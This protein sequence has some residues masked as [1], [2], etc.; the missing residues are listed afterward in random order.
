MRLTEL[1]AP[2]SSNWRST[3]ARRFA[4]SPILGVNAAIAS[5]STEEQN[6]ILAHLHAAEIH[7]IRSG[8]LPDENGVDFA[9]RARAQGIWIDWLVVRSSPDRMSV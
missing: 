5:V 4:E 8:I 3:S 7:Y 6:E 9:L 2:T 1:T